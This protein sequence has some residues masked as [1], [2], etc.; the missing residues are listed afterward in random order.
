MEL[1]KEMIQQRV[2]TAPAFGNPSVLI[3]EPPLVISF[4]QIQK[5]LEAFEN[6][7][8]KLSQGE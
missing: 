5:V 8:K 4:D 6:T 7:C 2:L 1:A 3:I